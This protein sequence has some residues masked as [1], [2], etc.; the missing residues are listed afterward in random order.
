[1]SPKPKAGDTMVRSKE[2]LMSE[3]AVAIA[4]DEHTINHLE[5]WRSSSTQRKEEKARHAQAKKVAEVRGGLDLVA[6]KNGVPHFGRP[7]AAD[8]RRT[9]GGTPSDPG[10]QP[11]SRAAKDGMGGD[12]DPVELT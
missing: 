10:W 4:I 2:L 7:M 8:R 5:S 1:M 6:A 3:W 12:H 11:C 9:T